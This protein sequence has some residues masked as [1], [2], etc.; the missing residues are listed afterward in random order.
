MSKSNLFENFE[1]GSAKAWKQK[2]Q[3]EL[4]G[5]DFNDHLVWNS[6]EGIDVKPFYHSEAYS[7]APDIQHNASDWNIGHSIYVNSVEKSNT[8]A[9]KLIESG[10]ESLHFTL[11]TVSISVEELLKNIDT[12]SVPIYF[13]PLCLSEKLIKSLQDFSLKNK[14]SFY[15]L[16]DPIGH[17]ARSGNWHENLKTD[18]HTLKQTIALGDTLKSV[19]SVDLGLFQNAGGSMIQ[20]LAYTLA[21]ANEYLNLFDDESIKSVVFK[22]SVGGN[23]FFEIAKLQA[24]RVLWYSLTKDYGLSIDCHILT[25]PSRRNK[26]IYDYNINMLR[27][28]TECMSAILGSSDTIINMPYDHLYHKDNDFGNRLSRNQLLILKKES[29]FDAVSNPTEGAYYIETLTHQ[30]AQK[31]LDLFK[32][33]EKQGGFLKLLKEGMVQRKLKEHAQ[34]EQRLYDE[35]TEGL[36]GTHFQQNALDTMKSDLEIYPFIKQLA[37]K[38]LLEPIIPRRISEELEQKRLKDE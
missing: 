31:S 30:L 25:Q 29:Y 24:L 28:T 10:V 35:G 23:Y 21:H 7:K 33:I 4:Q 22:V 11:P 36:L 1:S 26:T 13:E 18:L 5:K 27:T 14:T 19:I 2:I 8:H 32:D 38:T 17:L 34:K 6:I 16:Q 20:Q 12:S 9:L 15:I 3:F 37:R